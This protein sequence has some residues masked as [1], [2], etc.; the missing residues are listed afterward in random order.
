MR[1]LAA[2]ELIGSPLALSSRVRLKVELLRRHAIG[3]ATEL[4]CL[5]GSRAG[6]RRHGRAVRVRRNGRCRTAC[7]CHRDL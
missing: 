4:R 2:A 1:L 3:S 7:C 5:T 6:S